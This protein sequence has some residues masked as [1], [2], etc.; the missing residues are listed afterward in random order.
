LFFFRRQVVEDQTESIRK[1]KDAVVDRDEQIKDAQSEHMRIQRE[2]ESQL[3]AEASETQSHSEQLSRERS[4]RD[5][6]T[7]VV[8]DLQTQLADEQHA[9]AMLQERWRVKTEAVA[10][11]E[12]QVRR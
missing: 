1:L 3:A 7:T 10:A 8:G 12:R 2:L 11:V 5:E 4:R 6:L 9:H